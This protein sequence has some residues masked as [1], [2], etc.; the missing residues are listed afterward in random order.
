MIEVVGQVRYV[1]VF[2]RGLTNYGEM[3]TG[4]HDRIAAAV[5][6]LNNDDS[7]QAVEA[8]V[9][10]GWG[11]KWDPLPPKTLSEAGLMR[12]Y[13]TDHGIPEDGILWSPNA[14]DTFDNV[15]DTAAIF[16]HHGLRP[17][18]RNRIAFPSGV[19]HSWRQRWLTTLAMGLPLGA[20]SGAFQRIH[21]D[22]DSWKTRTAEHAATYLTGLALDRIGGVN[23]DDTLERRTDD[24]RQ[25]QSLMN[26]WLAGVRV[27][28]PLVLGSVARH[29]LDR[30]LR[31]PAT[32]YEAT[33]A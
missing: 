30:I 12:D 10:S 24:M 31:K 5:D 2:G 16:Q 22:E 14:R 9:L 11:S 13:A 15:M 26:E 27:R 17:D 23:P 18:T 33:S 7:G 1:M 29:E 20:E 28:N 21:V 25:A 4:T 19:A 6:F 8:L 32:P 3:T